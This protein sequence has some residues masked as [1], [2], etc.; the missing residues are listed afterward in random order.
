MSSAA[1]PSVAGRLHQTPR[2]A[3]ARAAGRAG[4]SQQAG[5]PGPGRVSSRWGRA[6]ASG[7]RRRGLLLLL[8]PARG[9]LT[10]RLQPACSQEASTPSAPHGAAR[11]DPGL[12]ARESA[13]SDGYETGC[14]RPFRR[15][16][17]HHH[18]LPLLAGS[19][20]AAAAVMT[21]GSA[22]LRGAR[23]PP[24][25]GQGHQP[26][27]GG[28]GAGGGHV[29]KAY[30]TAPRGGRERLPGVTRA[31]SRGGSRRGGLPAAGK[32]RWKLENRSL[33]KGAPVSGKHNFL[34]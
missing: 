25:D 15:R 11:P 6:H 21:N 16:S 23:L 5:R 31:S 13:R 22:A 10:W 9:L 17:R 33:E 3:S 4:P 20:R 1:P 19:A 30:P 12:A 34:R 32:V 26:I 28:L 29:A 8:Q 24:R 18:R 2:G 27:A 7:R 14:L